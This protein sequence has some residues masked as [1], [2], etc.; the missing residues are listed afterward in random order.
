MRIATQ[1]TLESWGCHVVCG[2]S[3]VDAIRAL[4]E[5]L[6]TPDLIICDYRLREG[7]NGLDAI[8]AV[9]ASIGESPPALIITGDIGAQD[10]SAIAQRGIPVAH[11]PLTGSRLKELISGLLAT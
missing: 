10:I 5:H 6:R 3:A 2:A 11:K 8:D 1:T 4:H 9:R 7:M